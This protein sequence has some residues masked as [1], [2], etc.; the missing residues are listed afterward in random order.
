VGSPA[1]G[2][3]RERQRQERLTALRRRLVDGPV[4]VIRLQAMHVQFDPRTLQPLGEHG[5]VYPTLRIADTW[6]V[7]TVDGAALLHSDWSAVSVPANG[8][9]AGQ[10]G[11]TVETEGWTLEL[12]DG[13]AIVPGTRP[14]DFALRSPTP[15]NE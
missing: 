2:A 1:G 5:T 9:E 8:I 13:W 15:E 6:G 11:G 7:L 4:L 10:V 14:G 12:A 3:V